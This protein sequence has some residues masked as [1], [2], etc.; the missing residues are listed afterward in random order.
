MI[1]E[2]MERPGRFFAVTQLNLIFSFFLLPANSQNA[3]IEGSFF[4]LFLIQ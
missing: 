4:F 2:E 1:V 3:N